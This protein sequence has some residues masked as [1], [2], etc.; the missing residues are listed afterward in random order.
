MFFMI[1][2]E[3]CATKTNQTL[4]WKNNPAT[5][6]SVLE[7]GAEIWQLLEDAGIYNLQSKEV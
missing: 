6:G 3:I 7:V 5:P 1:I 4:G 2:H